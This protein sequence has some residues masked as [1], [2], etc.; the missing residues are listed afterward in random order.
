VVISE[1]DADPASHYRATRRALVSLLEGQQPDVLD[2]TVA[3][4]PDW[5][6]RDVVAH[7]VGITA[8]LNAGHLPG[9]DE[10]SED[11]TA[12][13]VATRGGATIAE[14][15]HEW[16]L[17]A[18]RFEEGLTLFGYELGSHFLGDLLQH[19]SDIRATLGVD[20][21]TDD[22]TL[23]VALDFY[24]DATH[25]SLSDDAD[26]GVALV[27]GEDRLTLGPSPVVA[28]VVTDRFEAFRV[29]GGRRSLAQIRA[30]HWAGDVDRVAHRLS[31]YPVP[32]VDLVDP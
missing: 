11:W 28:E 14:L 29:L 3:A 20:R 10:D 13:Q 6:I 2:Q 19:V 32:T 27:L 5:R 8:D 23:A 25:R 30:L 17:E 4:C 18:P 31:R 7:L 21:V 12:R 26:G 22:L 24:A 1:H 9:P 16:E 15:L